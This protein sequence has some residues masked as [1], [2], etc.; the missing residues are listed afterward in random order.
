[1]LQVLRKAIKV[2]DDEGDESSSIRLRYV[3]CHA[4]LL[5]AEGPSFSVKEVMSIIDK[6]KCIF[7]IHPSCLYAPCLS[8][9]SML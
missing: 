4:I 5:G 1:M 8:L 2:A 6:V 9:Q 3:L 7:A